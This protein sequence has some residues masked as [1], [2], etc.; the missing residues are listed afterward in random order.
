MVSPEAGWSLHGR[1][2][3]DRVASGREICAGEICARAAAGRCA[4]GSGE[5]GAGEG[6]GRAHGDAGGLCAAAQPA[7]RYFHLHQQAAGGQGSLGGSL[8]LPLD[9]YS[10]PTGDVGGRPE[11]DPSFEVVLGAYTACF[12]DYV[13][14]E[15][16]YESDLPDNDSRVK[17]SRG[18]IP[19]FRTST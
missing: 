17:S 15:L 18:T 1:R 11:F 8:R 7:H 16:K 12:N 4:A 14:R 19:M 3:A 9:G 10:L 13:R 6:S 2:P 5:S